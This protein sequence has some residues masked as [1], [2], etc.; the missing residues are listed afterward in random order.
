MWPEGTPWANVAAATYDADAEAFGF[1]IR[2]RVALRKGHH[3]I[4]HGV[5][6]SG[7]RH[8]VCRARETG[9]RGWPAE[10][11]AGEL[12]RPPR[13]SGTSRQ[14]TERRC[15]GGEF[16][17]ASKVRYE[18]SGGRFRLRSKTPLP[19]FACRSATRRPGYYG[20]EKQSKIY[21]CQVVGRNAGELLGQG[22][23]DICARELRKL[24]RRRKEDHA[25]VARALAPSLLRRGQLQWSTG[26]RLRHRRRAPRRCAAE[27]AQHL[28][29]HAGVNIAQRARDETA[30][31]LA[32][33]GTRVS[34][35]N[36]SVNFLSL[37]PTIFVSI[38]VSVFRNHLSL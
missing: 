35:W 14:R 21:G 31:R 3:L 17:T 30:R 8:V 15:D 10:P 18:R 7:D 5:D 28:A 27:L 29:L 38:A 37:R 32:R 13:A 26:C 4:P 16:V 24:S 34:T 1:R 25:L 2:I 36:T 9:S 22:S 33:F 12:A 19:K 23:E 6:G 20:K 11:E